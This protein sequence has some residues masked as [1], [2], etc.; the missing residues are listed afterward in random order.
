[1]GHRPQ[2]PEHDPRFEGVVVHPDRIR[3]GGLESGH[4]REVLPHVARQ[5]R[6]L[7]GNLEHALNVAGRFPTVLLRSDQSPR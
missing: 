4:V 1:M 5:S 6:K 3:A 2:R 7:D